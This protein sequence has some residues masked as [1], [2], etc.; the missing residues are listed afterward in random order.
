MYINP[1]NPY[2][3]LG[4]SRFGS[5]DSIKRAYHKMAK[6]YHPDHGGNDKMIVLINQA[7]EKLRKRRGF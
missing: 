2:A 3:I 1:E 6:K 5:K 7:Y 4:V